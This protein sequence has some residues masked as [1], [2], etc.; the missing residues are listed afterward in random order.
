MV[1]HLQNGV[2]CPEC[3]RK[4]TGN[5]LS[6]DRCKIQCTFSANFS[7]AIFISCSPRVFFG[8]EEWR[9]EK[10]LSATPI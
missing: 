4:G 6:S 1:C 2:A 7:S 8:V 5:E 3:A 10:K 9:E